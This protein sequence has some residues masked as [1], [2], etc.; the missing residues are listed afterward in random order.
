MTRL[1]T[2]PRDGGPAEPLPMPESGAGD[3]SPD[4]NERRLLAA[5]PRLPI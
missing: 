3:F 2:V 4:G 1:Y 5:L